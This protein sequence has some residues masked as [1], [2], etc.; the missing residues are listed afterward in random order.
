MRQGHLLLLWMLVVA[1]PL[2]SNEAA[3]KEELTPHSVAVYAGSLNT[4]PMKEI[5]FT[6]WS[7]KYEKQKIVAVAYQY[8]VFDWDP[9]FSIDW[10]FNVARLYNDRNLSHFSTLPLFRW[11]NFPWND[12]I[13]TTAAIGFFGASVATDIIPEEYEDDGG[14]HYLNFLIPEITLGL[15][16]YPHWDFLVRIH[17]RSGI[18][19]AI[20]GVNGGSNFLAAGLRYHF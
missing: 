2:W 8:R 12:F 6:P 11:K 3:Q 17:H 13:R 5:L 4:Q 16:A 9:Y 7:S 1:Q 18:F 14:S 15:P 20:S 19:G 10:E